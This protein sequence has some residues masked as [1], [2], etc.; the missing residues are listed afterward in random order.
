MLCW[1]EINSPDLGVKRSE[2]KVKVTVEGIR[3]STSRVELDFSI[4]IDT[5]SLRNLVL[6]TMPDIKPNSTQ[7]SIPTG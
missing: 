7:P 5:H 4:V 1:T 2:V 3:Y 6:T